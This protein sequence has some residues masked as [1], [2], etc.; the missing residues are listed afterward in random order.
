MQNVIVQPEILSRLIHNL[1]PNRNDQKD[2]RRR[3][4]IAAPTHLTILTH[5]GNNV[6]TIQVQ[7]RDISP[8]GIGLLRSQPMRLDEPFIAC[9]PCDD[10]ST[11]AV[12]AQVAYW[13][14][15]AER[16]FSIGCKFD[17]ILTSGELKDAA[18]TLARAA[19]LADSTADREE[20]PRRRSA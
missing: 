8:D 4:R 10:G 14:P 20:K 17:R 9:L 19:A 1:E 11:T 15:L 12:L 2:S 16:L 7:V 5:S 13:E 3:L 18:R 6:L